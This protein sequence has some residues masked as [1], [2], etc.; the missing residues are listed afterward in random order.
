MP[1]A[2]SI[3]ALLQLR[4][5]E[6]SQVSPDRIRLLETIRQKGSITAAAKALGLSYKGA[7]DAVQAMN[8]VFERPLVIAQAGGRAGGAA[9]VTSAGEAVMLAYRRL[10]ADLSE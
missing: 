5:N 7:W 1:A 3:K 2:H 10:E 6:R 9:T 8:N 4:R